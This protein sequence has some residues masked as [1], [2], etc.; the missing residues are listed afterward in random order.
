MKKLSEKSEIWD[1]FTKY[2]PGNRCKCNYCGNNYACKNKYRNKFGPNILQS[3]LFCCHDYLSIFE[4]KNQTTSCAMK[5]KSSCEIKNEY[6]SHF[7]DN[8]EKNL[9]DWLLLMNYPLV[10]WRKRAFNSIVSNQ[11]QIVCITT[12]PWTSTQ[13]YYYLVIT[14]YF[15]D[16][17]WKLQKRIELGTMQ[18]L[19]SP[20]FECV[21][22]ER[23]EGSALVIHDVSARWN[24]TYLLL[25]STMK[26][27]KAFERMEDND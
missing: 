22:H 4:E 14:I 2:D 18:N 8:I 9:Q 15:F 10:L 11:N 7:L 21:E 25:E 13:N 27:H 24:S 12:D 20:N 16:S 26:F 5:N 17:K 6:K 23:I 1:H 3:H 19:I